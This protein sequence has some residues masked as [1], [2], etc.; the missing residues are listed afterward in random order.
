MKL[1][2]NDRST[3]T[4][5]RLKILQRFAGTTL[6]LISGWL[7]T[8]NIYAGAARLSSEGGWRKVLLDIEPGETATVP[9]KLINQSAEMIELVSLHVSCD[10]VATDIDG[11]VLIPAGRSHEIKVKWTPHF[12]EGEA[13]TSAMLR[14]LTGKQ[15]QYQ[16]IVF[17]CRTPGRQS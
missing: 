2:H 7:L 5:H 14:Y 16:N 4:T 10:C 1:F 6:L 17:V 8:H 11:P 12:T 13:E 15:I 3:T 9:V